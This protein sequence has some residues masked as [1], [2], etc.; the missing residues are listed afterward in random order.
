MSSSKPSKRDQPTLLPTNRKLRELIGI[1][2]RNLTIAPPSRTRGKTIDDES[3]PNTWRSPSK[4]LAQRDA[5]QPIAHSRSSN[6][7]R[8]VAARA[9]DLSIKNAKS[10]AVVGGNQNTNG[11]A[12]QERL[13]KAM[14]SR[15]ADVWFS[16]QIRGSTEPVYI[17]EIILQTMNPTFRLF[18]LKSLSPDITRLGEVVVKFWA[19]THLIPDYIVLLELELNLQSLQFIGKSLKD[20]HH[21]LPLNCVIFHLSDGLYTNLTNMAS[22]GPSHSP[23]AKFPSEGPPSAS[24]DT[25]MRLSALDDCAQDALKTHKKLASQISKILIQHRAIEGQAGE[26]GERLAAIEMAVAAEKRRLEAALR[27]HNDIKSSIAARR[28]GMAKGKAEQLQAGDYLKSA[29]A[30]LAKSVSALKAKKDC[31]QDERRKICEVL[32]TIFPIAETGHTLCFEIC[33]LSLPN[34]TFTTTHTND[35]ITGAALG[36]AAHLVYLL[37]FYLSVPLIY[38]IFPHLSSTLIADPVSLMPGQRTFPL[39]AN[40]SIKYRFEYAVFLLNKN[41]E[42]LLNSVKVKAVDIRQTLPNLKYLLYMIASGKSGMPPTNGP[43]DIGSVPSTSPFHR[44]WPLRPPPDEGMVMGDASMWD[45]YAP[46]FEGPNSKT[47]NGRQASHV[48]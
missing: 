1:S 30:N 9:A 36:F 27:T 6:D 15:L 5:K 31:L 2:M 41:I 20:F 44:H 17:S 38:P 11:R 32:M 18:D 48:D 25:M 13:E 37:S 7:L 43:N 42:C 19:K 22:Q 10:P 35:T 29:A 21:P 3:L 33:G 16:L 34:S 28:E 8:S 23:S 26:S 40:G 46:K 45:E 47:E 39:Y 12:R 14:A 24:Y 4:I